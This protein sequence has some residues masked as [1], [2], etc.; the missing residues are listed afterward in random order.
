MSNG[1]T[2]SNRLII[3]LL[4]PLEVAAP[5]GHVAA[6]KA[7]TARAL[8]AYLAANRFR[9]QRRSELA[10]LLWGADAGATG[11]TNLRSALRRVRN[12]VILE[13]SVTP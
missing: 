1:P 11:L 2:R 8:L 7:A 13:D 4:G 10:T 3:R 12:A 9:P 6:S 5:E